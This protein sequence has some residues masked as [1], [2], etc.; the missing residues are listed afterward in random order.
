M[1]DL[2]EKLTISIP[3]WFDGTATGTHAIVGLVTVALVMA[4]MSLLRLW[5]QNR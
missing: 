4:I 3:G 1:Q 2:S 5:L